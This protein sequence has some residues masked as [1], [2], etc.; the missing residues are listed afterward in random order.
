MKHMI[1]GLLGGNFRCWGPT[2]FRQ[3]HSLFGHSG[4]CGIEIEF[5]TSNRPKSLAVPWVYTMNR[6][7]GEDEITRL[8]DVSNPILLV[9]ELQQS[10]RE[11]VEVGI[12]LTGSVHLNHQW[13]NQRS[14]SGSPYYR[15][16]DVADRT[17]ASRHRQENKHGVASYNWEDILVQMLISYACLR[18]ETGNMRIQNGFKNVQPIDTNTVKMWCALCYPQNRELTS[19]LNLSK[20]AECK[21]LAPVSIKEDRAPDLIEPL[22]RAILPEE[23]C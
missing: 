5:S 3:Y 9:K 16:N 20:P 22:R 11:L 6:H 8:Y 18:E 19:I 4:Y 17:P 7:L 13:E 10:W 1:E 21:I 23:R 15:Q 2:Q 12:R 14:T